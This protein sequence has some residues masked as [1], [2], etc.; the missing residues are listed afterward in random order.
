[1]DES[2]LRQGKGDI[3]SQVIRAGKRTYFFD[4]RATKGEDMYLTLT[5]SKRFYNND[6][7]KFQYEKHKI[8]LF[9]EDFEKFTQ[10]LKDA[11]QFIETIQQS[12]FSDIA[13]DEEH[14]NK[15]NLRI[16]PDVS[17]EDLD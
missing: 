3:Y 9:K 6:S 1:M 5:E 17:F 8:F 11:I 7:G 4:V 10:G 16:H 14:L 2:I 15:E 12:E 13:D